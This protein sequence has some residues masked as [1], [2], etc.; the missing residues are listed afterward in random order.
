[1]Q[2]TRSVPICVRY[3]IPG[4]YTMEQ[5]GVHINLVYS[6]FYFTEAI[7]KLRGPEFNPW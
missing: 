2:I 6:D 1:M 4:K 7:L 5:S 3:P